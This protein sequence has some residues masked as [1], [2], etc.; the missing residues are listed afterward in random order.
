[1]INFILGTLLGA[2]VASLIILLLSGRRNMKKLKND[3]SDLSD[4]LNY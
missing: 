2:A 4:F 1:M 3:I